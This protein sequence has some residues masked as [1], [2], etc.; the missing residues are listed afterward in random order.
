M[1]SRRFPCSL[2]SLQVLFV[3]HVILGIPLSLS[4]PGLDMFV[5]T[6]RDSKF[7]CG[8]ISLG[9]P[10]SGEGITPGCGHRGLEL[11]CDG[12][13]T[14]L[15]IEGVR[16]KVLHF[17]PVNRTLKI[18]RQ[19]LENSLCNPEPEGSIFDSTLFNITSLI[20]GYANVTLL[21]DCP[22]STGSYGVL[23]C[24]MKGTFTRTCRSSSKE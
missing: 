17:S 8:G 5:S 19:D 20:P 4:N 21:Y 13:A 16:Y 18:A 15:E 11:S 12:G 24:N 7:E 22:F 3:S 23:N 14:M 1:K 2:F 6:C 9:Y 10:F